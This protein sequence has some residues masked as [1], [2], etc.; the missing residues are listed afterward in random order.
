MSRS[1]P[2]CAAPALQS[3][4]F[5]PGCS[6]VQFWKTLRVSCRRFHRSQYLHKWTPFLP[7]FG[8]IGIAR[9]CQFLH[10]A[11]ENPS[12]WRK[13]GILI[14]ITS[15]LRQIGI[16]I[17]LCYTDYRKKLDTDPLKTIDK[18]HH[19]NVMLAHV[20]IRK[21]GLSRIQVWYRVHYNDTALTSF[22][23]IWIFHFV[24]LVEGAFQS[25]FCGNSHLITSDGRQFIP[26]L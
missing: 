10:R 24:F 20:S 14:T 3:V 13:I 2:I 26:P 12:K 1:K 15:E 22:I 16:L 25:D 19:V 7:L 18:V 11:K 4:V 6:R 23:W 17:E 8:P 21:L 9:F 5:L